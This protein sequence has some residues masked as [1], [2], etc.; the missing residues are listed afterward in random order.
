MPQLVKNL[1]TRSVLAQTSLRDAGAAP[2]V[3]KR[4]KPMKRLCAI[5]SLV[6]LLIV[7]A[8]P[9]IA[10]AANPAPTPDGWTWDEV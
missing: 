7:L 8:L 9:A 6:L 3:Q 5:L 2:G 1:H 10:R 4:G